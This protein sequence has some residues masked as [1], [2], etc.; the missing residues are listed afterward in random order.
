VQE[1]LDANPHQLDNR[2]IFQSNLL[3][4]AARNGQTDIVQELLNR[5]IGVDALDFVSVF[6]DRSWH[7]MCI[8]L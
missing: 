2:T 8:W 6:P 4:I 3:H 7:C 1:Y 5:G